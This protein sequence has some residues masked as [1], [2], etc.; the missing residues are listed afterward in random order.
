MTMMQRRGFTLIELS[1][2]LTII[3]MI[4]AGTISMGSSMVQSR[5]RSAPIKSSTPLKAP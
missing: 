3:A 5:R 4:I 1:I 2:V